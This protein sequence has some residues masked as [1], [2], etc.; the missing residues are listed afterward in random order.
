VVLIGMAWLDDGASVVP[1]PEHEEFAWWPS[2]V[3]SWP[4][5]G[6]EPLRRM[7]AMLAGA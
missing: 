2:E 7:G 4:P 1:D 6:D 3:E 5:E